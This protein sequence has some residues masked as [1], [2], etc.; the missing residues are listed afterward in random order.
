MFILYL[1]KF[2]V[3]I[4]EF[5][6]E[7]LR[8]GEILNVILELIEIWLKLL[9]GEVE[10]IL[11]VEINMCDGCWFVIKVC[12][13]GERVIVVMLDIMDLKIFEVVLCE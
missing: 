2:G 6:E 4:R 8:I 10:V 3:M 9:C 11:I 12:R 5:F 13:F 1:R 7:S